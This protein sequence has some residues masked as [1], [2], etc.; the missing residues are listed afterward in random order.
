MKQH[1][2]LEFR[3]SPRVD[4]WLL[5]LLSRTRIPSDWKLDGRHTE[6]SNCFVL[7]PWACTPPEISSTE[8]FSFSQT[9][10]IFSN[11]LHH[12]W[13]PSS[14]LQLKTFEIFELS[15]FFVEIF[16]PIRPQICSLL[17]DGFVFYTSP[18]NFSQN[19][20]GMRDPCWLLYWF[21]RF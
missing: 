21:L 20:R 11:T 2:R 1:S 9:K 18:P 19:Q 5:R 6:V 13:K 3:R 7:L 4:L 15:T 12:F 10:P 8:A 17:S 14:F 16:K